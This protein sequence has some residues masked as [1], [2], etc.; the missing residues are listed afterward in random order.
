MI[1][2]LCAVARVEHLIIS[3]RLLAVANTLG[4]I[5]LVFASA[6]TLQ[7]RPH[8][9]CILCWRG[10]IRVGSSASLDRSPKSNWVEKSG[11]LPPYVREIARS[12]E[13]TGKSLSQAIAIAISRIKVWAAGGDGVSA[14]TSA[15]AAKALAQW[16]SLKA[17]NKARK[18]AKV[19][20][21][22]W[23]DLQRAADVVELSAIED[24]ALQ[25]SVE[26]S[27]GAGMVALSRVLRAVSQ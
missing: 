11:E 2:A 3:I 14:K 22:H 5:W 8:R 20:A 16:E 18:G 24:R 19:A 12:V 4:G 21:S 17:K 1:L 9:F 7:S 15:K 13:K 6:A 10:W 25:L 23:D 26:G 27:E